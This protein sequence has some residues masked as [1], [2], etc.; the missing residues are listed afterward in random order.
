MHPINIIAVL[1]LFCTVCTAVDL[2]KFQDKF[3]A[4]LP[5]K[6]S[7]ENT[8]V[9]R[10]RELLCYTNC[11]YY[12]SFNDTVNLPANCTGVQSSSGCYVKIT[13]DYTKLIVSLNLYPAETHL[14]S[15]KIIFDKVE[16]HYFDFIFISNDIAHISTYYCT[17]DDYCA[18]NYAKEIIPKL[19]ALNYE[20]LYNSLL[21][22]LYHSG[23]SPNVTLC[24]DIFTGI[25]GCPNGSCW[26]YH[27]LFGLLDN[28][29]CYPWDSSYV[30]MATGIEYY[31]LNSN[32]TSYNHLEFECNIDQC[33]SDANVNEIKEIIRT[34]GNEYINYGTSSTSTSTTSAFNDN[35]TS[36]GT[37]TTSA[38]NDNTTS[39]G[40][41]TTSAF[42]NTTS[43]SI[44]IQL[45]CFYIVLCSW[46]FLF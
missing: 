5:Q 45:Q 24:H 20:P 33:N 3:R 44:E 11:S 14:G 12:G 36:T 7:N 26:Y 42:D 25:T 8:T 15:N 40:T 41:S 6:L 9:L 10:S 27:L 30:Y 2:K 13:L 29:S 16:Y 4:D 46:T 1:G 23:S 28:R 17:S 18:W 34:Q 39:T 22:K 19:I 37:S 31:V 35:T 38:F 43:N 32:I 21:P